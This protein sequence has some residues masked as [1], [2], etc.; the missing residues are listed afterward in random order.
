[1]KKNKIKKITIK[2]VD[3]TNYYTHLLKLRKS[4]LHLANKFENNKTNRTLS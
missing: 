1:M 2:I 3:E 4:I